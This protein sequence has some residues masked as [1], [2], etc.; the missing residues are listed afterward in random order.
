VIVFVVVLGLILGAAA[1]AV[2]I[3]ARETFYVGLSKSGSPPTLVIYRGRPG[4]L[5]WFQPTVDSRTPWTTSQVLPSRVPDLQRGKIEP[6]VASAK[7]YITRLL[8]EQATNQAAASGA[9]TTPGTSTTVADTL[10]PLPPLQGAT[11][12]VP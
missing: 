6:S 4:G 3:Y 11:T 7:A 9:A 5:L 10:P 2:T 12:T 1:G 8:A